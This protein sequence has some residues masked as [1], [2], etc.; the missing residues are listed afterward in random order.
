MKL[1]GMRAQACAHRTH[2]KTSISAHA[3]HACMR[4]APMCMHTHSTIA[5]IFIT[6]CSAVRPSSSFLFTSCGSV[7]YAR[8]CNLVLVTKLV[9]F[10]LQ[11]AP[12]RTRGLGVSAC[13]ACYTCTHACIRG[14]YLR[15]LLLHLLQVA[16]LSS[17]HWISN[18]P[19]LSRKHKFFTL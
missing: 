12:T 2:A 17:L 7:P 5:H 18:H 8:A 6:Q 16:F 11:P 3:A 1:H 14:H 10:S 13:S 19:P 9:E 15:H 4:H